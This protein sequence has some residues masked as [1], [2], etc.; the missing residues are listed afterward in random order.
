MLMLMKCAAAFLKGLWHGVSGQYVATVVAHSS[1]LRELPRAWQSLACLRSRPKDFRGDSCRTTSDCYADCYRSTDDIEH[2]SCHDKYSCRVLPV[3][4]HWV[5]LLSAWQAKHQQV[6]MSAP[7]GQF[8]TLFDGRAQHHV[9][10]VRRTSVCS[11]FRTLRRSVYVY[12]HVTTTWGKH[13]DGCLRLCP[14][15]QHT[16]CVVVQ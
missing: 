3:S 2:I 8:T 16:A 4:S 11:E 15:P 14:C 12:M 7:L 13:Q 5:A 6:L 9:D 1:L 10:R